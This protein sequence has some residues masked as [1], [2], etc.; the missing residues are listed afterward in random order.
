MERVMRSWC[1]LIVSI[2]RHK[3]RKGHT[4]YEFKLFYHPCNAQSIFLIQRVY[5]TF[6]LQK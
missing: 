4:M 2:L 3:T 6:I 1:L 5:G